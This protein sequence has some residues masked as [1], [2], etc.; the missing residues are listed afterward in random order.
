MAIVEA[1]T[2]AQTVRPS[3]RVQQTLFD[4]RG[5]GV[6]ERATPEP[7]VVGSVLVVGNRISH[8]R[9]RHDGDFDDGKFHRRQLI[10]S[11]PPQ[12]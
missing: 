12:K 3:V 4:R 1:Y 11:R 5:G 7:K 6:V 8:F 10:L 9:K 2:K